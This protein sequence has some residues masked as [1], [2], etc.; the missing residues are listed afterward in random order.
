MAESV[1]CRTVVRDVAG[2]SPAPAT[3]TL[4]QGK[5]VPST[6]KKEGSI[7]RKK[8][9]LLCCFPAEFGL[10]LVSLAGFI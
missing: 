8:A 7:Q 6:A 4:G 3:K 5:S 1:A 9:L 2:S 10:I